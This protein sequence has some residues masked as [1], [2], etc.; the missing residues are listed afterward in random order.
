[1]KQS[2]SVI[3]PTPGQDGP[4]K[5]VFVIDDDAVYLATYRHV[6]T[7][8]GYRVDSAT[9]GL[10][11][12]WD[13]LGLADLLVIDMVMPD[14]DGLQVLEK[15]RAMNCAAEIMLITSIKLEEEVELLAAVSDL[16]LNITGI[17]KKPFMASYLLDEVEKSLHR[18]AIMKY[19]RSSVLLLQ[20]AI[21]KDRFV[22]DYR[23][24]Y[25]LASSELE[26][27]HIE[28]YLVDV[29]GAVEEADYDTNLLLR[30]CAMQ[31]FRYLLDKLVDEA[32]CIADFSSRPYVLR[33]PLALLCNEVSRATLLGMLSNKRSAGVQF[34]IAVGDREYFLASSSARAALAGIAQAGHRLLLDDACYSLIAGDPDQLAIFDE[35][36]LD[37]RTIDV[38]SPGYLTRSGV[39]HLLKRLRM[40]GV[41][42]G[43]RA[44]NIKI[45][46]LAM[47]KLGF[48][49]CDRFDPELGMTQDAVVH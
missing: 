26:Y 40:G 29:N 17:M 43:L 1:M 45:S 33:F 9:S 10:H 14:M 34:I 13:K 35:V 24:Y 20:E 8:A 28:P 11:V 19:S 25:S 47:I 4:P 5:R 22:L 32:G 31:Y 41:R 7:G 30:D 39:A 49:H 15:L 36:K 2:G 38:L 18:R 44:G 42:T 12:D 16:E 21:E 48:S 37:S 46:G 6:L 3:G 23:P 27:V